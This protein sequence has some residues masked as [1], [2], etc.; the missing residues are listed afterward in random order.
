MKAYS[1]V[2]SARLEPKEANWLEN[3]IRGNKLTTS[4][5]IRDLIREKIALEA[6]LTPRP[7]QQ[8]AP[9]VNRF[10]GKTLQD[11]ERELQKPKEEVQPT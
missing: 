9:A 8:A 5:V 7:Q 3:R 2:F 11:W 4:I 1:K 10:G 6:A